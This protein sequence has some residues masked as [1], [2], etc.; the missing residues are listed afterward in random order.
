MKQCVPQRQHVE[1]RA[2]FATVRYTPI[3]VTLLDQFQLV[4][5]GRWFTRFQD[6]SQE[7]DSCV[8]P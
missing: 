1:H 4:L 5:G 2:K 6:I 3:R 8:P 7:T